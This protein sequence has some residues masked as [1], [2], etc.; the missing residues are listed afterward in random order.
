MRTWS[1]IAWRWYPQSGHVYVFGVRLRTGRIEYHSAGSSRE[2]ERRVIGHLRPHVGERDNGPV[3]AG[4]CA[5]DTA[6]LPSV[7]EEWHVAV[8]QLIELED[9]QPAVR[10]PPEVEPRDRLLP[11][12]AALRVRDVR[13]VEARLRREDPVVDLVPPA[14]HAALDPEQLELVLREG[15]LKPG[16][17][18][19]AGA[20]P[21]RREAVHAAEEEHRLARLA[22]DLALRAQAHPRQLRAH[23]IAQ[24][25]LGEEQKVVVGPAQD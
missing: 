23:D 4:R 5:R 8:G 9:A 11:R 6:D 13:L 22:L 15:R 20:R 2:R 19:L 17:E 25:G 18:R 14:G 12:V 16:I 3:V 1:L 21:V 7:V 24:T 10:M